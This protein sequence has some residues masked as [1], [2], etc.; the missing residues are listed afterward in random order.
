M[1][2]RSTR[3]APPPPKLS[4][5]DA[6][7]RA[8]H[9]R[10]LGSRS[11]GA[12]KRDRARRDTGL[13]QALGAVPAHHTEGVG[14][15]RRA[16]ARADGQLGGRAPHDRI[17]SRPQPGPDAR[18]RRGRGRFPGD[19]R[20]AARRLSKGARARGQRPPAGPRVARWRAFP[21]RSPACAPRSRSNAGSELE[22][23]DS[24]VHRR[25]RRLAP[26]RRDGSRRASPRPHRDRV[27][28]VLRDGSRQPLGKDRSRISRDLPRRR[29]P[30]NGP[31][32]G[33]RGELRTRR[34]GRVHRAHGH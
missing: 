27:R 9:P 21:H 19:E 20:R 14:R 30:R 3:S 12:W 31:G 28:A 17:G 24:R 29:Q 18:Q 1:R 34:D 13:R 6:A 33:G 15:G 22:H 11:T 8:R 10:R 16:A 2:K 23:L 5:R 32:R 26:I 7:R 25:P 4:P